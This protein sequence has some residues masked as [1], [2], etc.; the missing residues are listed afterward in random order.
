[1]NEPEGRLKLGL[2]EVEMIIRDKDGNIKSIDKEVTN[3]DCQ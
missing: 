2:W 3:G 1:M